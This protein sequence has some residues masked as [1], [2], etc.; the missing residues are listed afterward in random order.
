MA[1]DVWI[2]RWV[3]ATTVRILKTAAT[4]WWWVV[5]DGRST[6]ATGWGAGITTLTIIVIVTARWGTITVTTTTT[7]IIIT[8]RAISTRC[9]AGRS[10]ITSWTRGTGSIALAAGDIRLGIGSAVNRNSFELTA[11]ELF[12][13]SL[14]VRSSLELDEASFAIAVATGLGVDD[15]EARLTSE[16]LKI[17]YPDPCKSL[18]WFVDEY[19]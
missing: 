4:T 13:C 5:I 16:V 11:V 15:I 9:A 8:A 17:L 3:V 2:S 6:A 14:E 19:A 1:I 18:S 12:Y 7:I 10:S